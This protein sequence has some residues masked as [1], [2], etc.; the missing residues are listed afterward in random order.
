MRLGS[1][2]EFI[3]EY[4]DGYMDAN[5]EEFEKMDVE[6]LQEKLSKAEGW[7]AGYYDSLMCSKVVVDN[8]KQVMR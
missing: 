4:V 5:R 1:R 6:E 7:A 8:L 2:D 3:S